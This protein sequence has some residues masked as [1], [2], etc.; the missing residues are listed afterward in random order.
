[1]ESYSD[2][3]RHRFDDGAMVGGWWEPSAE[4]RIE[5]HL[6]P[7]KCSLKDGDKGFCFVRENRNGQIA[8][9]TYGRS[10]GFCIDP[11]EKKPLNHFLPGTPVLS[12]GTTG[13]NLGCK[14]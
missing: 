6:C 4:G 8:L 11:I 1:M 3:S 10:T 7:R 9:S 2:V 13:C 12:F 14:F 5:C